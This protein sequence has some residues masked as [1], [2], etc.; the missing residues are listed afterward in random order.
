MTTA[1]IAQRVQVQDFLFWEARLLDERRFGE[2]LELFTDDAYYWVPLTMGQDNPHDMVSIVY[3]DRRALETR[4]RQLSKPSRHAQSPQSR[5]NHLVG[6]VTVESVLDDNARLIVR[7]SQQILEWRAGKQRV[8]AGECL[9][10]V[11]IRSDCMKIAS[12]RV[13][14]IDC[15]GAHGGM[16]VP[17]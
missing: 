7:S 14:L 12:K 5:T 2:W 11:V 9:H 17:L 3:D 10:H 4:V 13:N 15:D 6:N 16:N 1:D 8:F